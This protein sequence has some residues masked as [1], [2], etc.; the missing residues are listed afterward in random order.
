MVGGVRSDYATPECRAKLVLT[1]NPDIIFTDLHSSLEKNSL[2]WGGGGGG[3]PATIYIISVRLLAAWMQRL[4]F[5]RVHFL[6][7]RQGRGKIQRAVSMSKHKSS[8]AWGDFQIRRR[9]NF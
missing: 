8:L 9:N 2:G 6:E 4:S 3:S 1:E 5:L 7:M